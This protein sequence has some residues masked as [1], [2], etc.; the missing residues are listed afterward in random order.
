M[1]RKYRGKRSEKELMLNMMIPMDITLL[2]VFFTIKPVV[3]EMELV[4]LLILMIG[5]LTVFLTINILNVNEEIYFIEDF[6]ELVFPSL[7]KNTEH[8]SFKSTILKR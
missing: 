3:N 1:N 4:I 2:T 5:V 7:H 8:Y 6:M